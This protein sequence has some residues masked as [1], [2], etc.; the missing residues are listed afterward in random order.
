MRVLAPRALP[1]RRGEV[2]ASAA[3]LGGGGDGLCRSDAARAVAAARQPMAEKLC[4]PLPARRSTATKS[5]GALLEPRPKHALI[6]LTH[7]PTL[8]PEY[9]HV[10]SVL[11]VPEPRPRQQPTPKYSMRAE[12]MDEHR[13]TPMRQQ[14]RHSRSVRRIAWPANR[15]STT[16]MSSAAVRLPAPSADRMLPTPCVV[17]SLLSNV[18]PAGPTMFTQLPF[19]NCTQQYNATCHFLLPSHVLPCP[20]IPS[21]LV[22]RSDQLPREPAVSRLPREPRPP[23]S[24]S[25]LPPARR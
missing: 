17:W 1:R 15:R 16:A 10:T 6:R 25:P 24:S 5:S 11:A 12:T 22:S 20:T 7:G 3:S 2:S 21:A 23:A 13:A 4:I 14:N 9:T 8:R 18:L 19:K